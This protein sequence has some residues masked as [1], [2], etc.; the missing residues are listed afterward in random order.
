MLNGLPIL[1]SGLGYREEI[2]SS[3]RGN[4]DQIDW[5]EII[6]EHFI[7]APADRREFLRELRSEFP[8]IPHGTELSIGTE[9]PLDPHYLAR[10]ADLVEDIDAPWFSDHL[11]FTRAGGIGLG[12]LTPIPRSRAAAKSAAKR[13]QQVQQAVGVPFIMENITYYI[14][15]PNPLGE[16]EFITEVM[17]NCDCGLL[18]DVTNLYI[19][20]RNHGFDPLEFLDGIPLERIVQ[21]HLAGH[22]EEEW[23]GQIID[24][25]SAPI[26]VPVWELLE[27]VLK[28]SPVRAAMIERDQEF[29]DDFSEILDDITSARGILTGCCQKMS[30]GEP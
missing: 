28:R 12:T 16:A 18:L 24:T 21:I 3:I 22:E 7:S 2:S 25:H 1:G 9:S 5:L 13:A 14:D 19:N 30:P 8:I 6:T 4:R 27:E 23:E 26:P 20:S 10:L 17:E 29:P 15:L 11:C